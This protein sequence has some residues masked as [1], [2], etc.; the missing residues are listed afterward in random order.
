[1]V[2]AFARVCS[3]CKES[4]VPMEAVGKREKPVAQPF[5]SKVSFPVFPSK[6][7]P[8]FRSYLFI[9]CTTHDTTNHVQALKF[10][11]KTSYLL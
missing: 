10:L 6:H 9:A 8:F 5:L 7:H 11:E 1:M 3:V 2:L 4:K